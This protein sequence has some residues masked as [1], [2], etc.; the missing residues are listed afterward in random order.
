L[1]LPSMHRTSCIPPKARH[2]LPK[3]GS[4]DDIRLAKLLPPLRS[5][6]KIHEPITT[7]GFCEAEHPFYLAVAA[8]MFPIR[9]LMKIGRVGVCCC[10]AHRPLPYGRRMGTGAA[11]ASM[12]SLWR[13]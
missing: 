11:G 5:L 3:V 13:P 2:P 10:A 4:L 1:P 7:T 9:A 8:L 6:V 12:P